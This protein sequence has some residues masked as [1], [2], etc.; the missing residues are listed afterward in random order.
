LQNYGAVETVKRLDFLIGKTFERIIKVDSDDSDDYS[1]ELR[2][3]MKNGDYYAFFHE[4]DC[5][6]LVEI[7]DICGTLADLAGSP[8]TLAEEY[9]HEN[10]TT[11]VDEV[12]DISKTYT[13]YKF[14][15]VK[16]YV[17]VRWCGESN[18]YYSEKVNYKAFID[19][20]KIDWYYD[21]RNKTSH[22]NTSTIS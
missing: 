7:A 6:E 14:G 13:F 21:H 11:A 18:G 2:F 8:I 17:T 19:G 4:Q 3:V 15:T 10:I 5:C 12:E 16:G 1:D 9:V 22:F 20:K